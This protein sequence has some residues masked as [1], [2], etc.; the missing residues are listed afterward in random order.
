MHPVLRKAILVTVS[1]RPPAATPSIAVLVFAAA[2]APLSMTTFL[3]AL[4]GM[5]TYFG[6][7]YAVIQLT[8]PVYLV[9]V[10]FLQLIVGPASDRFGRRPALLVSMALF[11]L[12]TA[13]ATFAQDIVSLLAARAIQGFAVGGMVLSRAIIRDTV[14]PDEAA[15]RLGYV[16]TAM[17]VIPLLG[18]S[19]GG[20]LNEIYGWRSVFAMTFVMGAIA[21]IVIYTS[22]PETHFARSRSLAEQSRSYR[23]LVGNARFW[24]YASTVAFV[25]GGFF[26][27]LG[28]GP[29][30]STELLGLSS[31]E[32]GIY[33]ALVSLGYMF[34]NF[35]SGRFARRAGIHRMMLWG[36]YLNTFGMGLLIV[37]F[38]LGFVHPVSLFLPTAIAAI[39]MGV[40]Q[41][42]AIAGIVSVRPDLAGSASGLG[43]TLQMGAGALF[44]LIVSWLL[45]PAA[46][47]W[48]VIL[49]MFLTALIAT[50]IC[51]VMGRLPRQDLNR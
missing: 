5:A 14:G 40:N 3:P 11:L 19:V 49:I 33:F 23:H 17:A 30:V 48:P 39:G 13:A 22:L 18:P 25:T 16:V 1:D 46:G 8:I 9:S 51:L 27:F 15:S 32:Y 6:T 12:G 35:L 34:G 50:A 42:S 24:G 29:Y 28:G 7:D 38:G 21:F 37:A 20:F 36:S 2:I 31:F 43:G 47:A 41:P 26:A 4:P 10:A 44:S 45:S